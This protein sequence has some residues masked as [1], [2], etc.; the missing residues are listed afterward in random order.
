MTK[1]RILIAILAASAIGPAAFAQDR[2][3]DVKPCS[4][5]CKLQ[6]NV[7][8]HADV[9]ASAPIDGSY[10]PSE[11]VPAAAEGISRPDPAVIAARK[12]DIMVETADDR[13]AR[14]RMRK[15]L[16]QDMAA[17]PAPIQALP[18]AIPRRSQPK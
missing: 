6:R 13:A 4:F 7:T 10:V 8:G 17:G 3:I 5:L 9:S 2:V 12:G 15:K 14:R 11:R 18:T 1:A 16:D